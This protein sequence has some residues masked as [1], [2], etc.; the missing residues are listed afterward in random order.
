[1]EFVIYLYVLPLL[2]A[3]EP[4]VVFTVDH[5]TVSSFL[6]SW[7]CIFSFTRKTILYIRMSGLKELPTKQTL[8]FVIVY[9]LYVCT[10]TLGLNLD[11]TKLFRL[12]FSCCGNRC[13]RLT[14]SLM[15]LTLCLRLIM[16]VLSFTGNGSTLSD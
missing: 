16:C 15:V 4:L 1:M 11:L 9:L 10:T 3:R 2:M 12:L 13:I 5:L 8:V 14:T 7:K 6:Y